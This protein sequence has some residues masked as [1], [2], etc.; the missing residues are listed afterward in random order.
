MISHDENDRPVDELNI[1]PDESDQ[2][3][4]IHLD[5]PNHWWA[6][7]EALWVKELGEGLYEI[8]NIPF[9]A[10]GLNYGDVV[11]ATADA[12]DLKPEIRSIVRHS[13]NKTL[14]LFI[15]DDDG[16]MEGQDAYLSKLVAMDTW[17]ERAT[18]QLICL[19][20]NPEADF[21]AVCAYLD[22]LVGGRVLQYETC[23]E[24]VSGSFDAAPEDDDDD[25]TL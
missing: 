18:K 8:R 21:D 9:C 15:P 1:S 20:V 11:F 22:R 16:G 5:L 17:F 19:N 10:Y 23:E 4:K 25:D 14:R 6:K 24:Q 2:L 12:P 3:T 13:G 7:G